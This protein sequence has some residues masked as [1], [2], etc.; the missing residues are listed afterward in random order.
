MEKKDLIIIIIL[1]VVIWGGL[2]WQE[3]DQT[4]NAAPVSIKTDKSEYAKNDPLKI[5]I[6]NNLGESICFS[7]CYPYY[8]EK[9]DGG[10][11]IYSYSQC[12]KSNINDICLTAHQAKF[13]EIDLSF[14]TAGIHRL[15]VPVCLDCKNKD[16][17]REDNKFYSNEFLIK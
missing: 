1:L 3:R 11:K 2:V 9:K 16:G 5:A 6:K 12:D 15:V 17:F 14:L 7:S 8:W 4:A 10:W 13:F